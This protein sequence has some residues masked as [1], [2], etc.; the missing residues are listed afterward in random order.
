MFF[1]HMM[2]N[3]LE[4]CAFL[5]EQVD[6]AF[7]K[8]CF[9][10]EMWFQFKDV[11]FVENTLWYIETRISFH[12]CMFTFHILTKNMMMMMMMMMMMI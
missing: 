5:F 8:N 9:S 6:V 11:V 10:P 12:V 3:Y 1:F 2:Q 4:T 7:L